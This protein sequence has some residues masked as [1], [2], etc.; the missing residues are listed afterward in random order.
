[1]FR[2]LFFW[3][4]GYQRLLGAVREISA[5]VRE[6]GGVGLDSTRAEQEGGN[7][8]AMH[9]ASERLETKHISGMLVER[10]V[11]DTCIGNRNTKILLLLH[12]YPTSE[13][14]ILI[15]FPG[16]LRQVQVYRYWVRDSWWN[17]LNLGG[18]LGGL[19]GI[20]TSAESLID[21]CRWVCLSI[22]PCFSIT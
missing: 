14:K 17:K 6:R 11:N 21:Q 10:A 4:G 2:F 12:K 19:L 16:T 9:E 5:R 22:F 8:G 15:L 18:S 3:G 13:K 1:V 20:G 7:M